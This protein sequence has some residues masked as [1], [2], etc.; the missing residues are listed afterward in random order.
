MALLTN[1]YSVN[2][3]LTISLTFDDGSVKN[4][5]VEVGDIITVV[6]NKN[7]VRTTVEGT[8]TNIYEM[9]ATCNCNCE[10]NWGMII[11]GTSYG[12]TSTEKVAESKI[13]DL[14]MVKKAVDS[15]AITSP[16]GEYNITDFR[17][18]GDILQ[19]SPDN[20]TTW[21]KVLTLPATAVT[22]A[23]G[24]EALATAVEAILPADLR[25]D[26]AASL[27]TSIITL[28]KKQT[29]SSTTTG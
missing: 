8:V 21:L 16:T 20:G 28:I 26:V 17:L 19:L 29:S 5:K 12:Y 13:L 18:V 3:S 2:H 27:E 14:T 9:E 10:S 24:D 23:S 11:D 22:V 15:S 1:T 6:Y 7:G 4:T 25:P